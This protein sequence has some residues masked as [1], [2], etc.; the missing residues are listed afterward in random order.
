M[1]A[2]VVIGSIN[3]AVNNAVAAGVAIVV[4]GGNSDSDACSTSPASATSAITVGATGT[5]DSRAFFSNYGECIDIFAP[6]KSIVSAK[7]NTITGSLS[8]SGTSMGAPHVAGVAALLLQEDP[9]L[10]PIGLLTKMLASA[11]ANVVTNP[12]TGSP[13]LLL[14]TGDITGPVP[15]PAPSPAPVL[16][17]VPSPAPSPAPALTPVPTL[18]PTPAPVP[19]PVCLA[20]WDTCT[21]DNQCCEK[22]AEAAVGMNQSCK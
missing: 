17:P 15:T 10:T 19:A 4:A 9:S 6:G 16:T 20:K 18:A 5:H 8:L 2:A 14:Y 11:T 7:T 3:T 21:A 22:N 12:G 13:N 1:D